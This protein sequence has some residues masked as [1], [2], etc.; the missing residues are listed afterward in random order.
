MNAATDNATIGATISVST[1]P[2]VK[3]NPPTLKLQLI[4]TGNGRDSFFGRMNGSAVSRNSTCE[5]PIVATITKTR[6]RLK[7]RRSV[8]SQSAPTAAARSSAA[9][10][11]I[12]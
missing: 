4:G 1:W 7:S 10:S 8:S 2:G 11:A 12:Q 3:T 5:S 6:G 9:T